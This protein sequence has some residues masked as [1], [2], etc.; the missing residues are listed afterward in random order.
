MW[1]GNGPCVL[2]C[3]KGCYGCSVATSLMNEGC[4]SKITSL[5]AYGHFHHDLAGV[6]MVGAPANDCCAGCYDLCLLRF[7]GN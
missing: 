7:P 4:C 3:H 2:T 6:K 5:R 1:Y